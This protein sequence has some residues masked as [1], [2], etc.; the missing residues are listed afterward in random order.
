MKTVKAMPFIF[1]AIGVILLA[2]GANITLRAHS[3]RSR[4]SVASGVVLENVWSSG[5][6]NMSYSPR[7]EFRTASGRVVHFVSRVSSQPPAFRE[8]ESVKVLYDPD[9]PTNASI[10]S[11]F[12]QWFGSLILGG[13]G[14]V[15]ALVGGIWLSVVARSKR[16]NEW[17]Q[18]NGT[19]V[20]AQLQGVELNRG[21]EVN[22]RNPYRIMAQWLNPATNR[23]HIFHSENLWFD[24]RRFVSGP[25]VQVLIDPNDPKRYHMDVSF[26][27]LEIE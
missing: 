3:F 22:G 26:L 7:V 9:D 21:L 15:F 25:T 19:R 16:L 27:P 23:I 10:D 14:L 6:R 5:S 4:A 1:L 18:I 17:L 2:I 13:L 8:G 12:E 11:F 20:L 24:P